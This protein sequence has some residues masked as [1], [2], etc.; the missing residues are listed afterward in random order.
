MCL[1]ALLL[2]LPLAQRRPSNYP[3]L[4]N[5]SSQRPCKARSS[6]PVRAGLQLR[7][8]LPEAGRQAVGQGGRD[9]CVRT[10][11]NYDQSLDEMTFDVGLGSVFLLRKWVAN[12]VLRLTRSDVLT[13]ASYPSSYPPQ[14]RPGTHS[15]SPSPPAPSPE[16]SAGRS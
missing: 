7:R 1:A 10:R 12:K 2:P 11:V 4:Q 15:A 6:E 14:P 9:R 8:L 3:S 5:L 13:S 16:L